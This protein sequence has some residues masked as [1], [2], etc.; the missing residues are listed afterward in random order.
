MAARLSF[1]LTVMTR[2]TLTTILLVALLL[3]RIPAIAQP[4]T[5]DTSDIVILY[6]NDVHGSVEGY[7]L[8][9]SLRDQMRQFTPNVALVSCGDFLSGIPYGTVS[10]GSYLVRLMN[11]VGYDYVTLGNHEFDFGLQTLQQRVAQLTAKVLCCNFSCIGQNRSIYPGYDIRCYGNRKVAFIGLTTPHVPA[12]STPTFFRGSLCRWLYTFYPTALDSLLQCRVDEARQD[13][14]DYVILLAHVGIDDMPHLVAS[15]SGIDAV[16]DGHSHSVIPHTILYNRLGKAVLWTSSGAYFRSFGRVVISANGDINSDLVPRDAVAASA[17]SATA[18]DDTLA[19][20][21]QEFEKKAHSWD[22]HSAVAL[23]RVDANDSFADCTLGNYFTDA[24]RA[25]AKADI[26]VMNRGGMRADLLQGDLTEGDFWAVA[27]LRNK[28]C[29]VEMTGQA[30]LDALEM[31]CR[32]WPTIGG[33]FLYVSGLTYEIDPTVNSPV[34][35]DKNGFLFRVEGK[36]RVCNVQVWNARKRRYEPLKPKRIYRVA[37]TDYILL[38]HG[39]GHVFN[40]VRVI[41]AAV[42]SHTK[43]LLVYLNDYLDFIIGDQYM[44]PEGRIRVR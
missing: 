25:V 38:H 11:A 13:G 12:L 35:T 1:F 31:G 30:L 36:R 37:G 39:N 24:F 43:A 3:G 41:D 17:A 15:T 23:R 8:M 26:A 28:L 2:R 7:P 44:R 4:Q 9:S 42:C 40:G 32:H 16:I 19:V 21:R 5:I 20:I 22:G 27:P 14:A 34:V 6:D 33:G 10:S 29:L 18:V